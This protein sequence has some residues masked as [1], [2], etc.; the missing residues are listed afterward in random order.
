MRAIQIDTYGDESVVK[1]RTVPI[2]GIAADE[3]LV[4]LHYA[5]INFM[6]IHTRQG[7]Y[8]TSRTYKVSV[9]TTLGMEGAGVIEAVGAA[10]EGLRPGQR[11]AYCLSWGTYADYAAVPAWRVV[12][13]PD[14]IAL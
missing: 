4:R 3:V 11:V 12:P 6:D 10:V 7:K 13:L 14:G 9:P 1:F 8:R 2:P 5:G